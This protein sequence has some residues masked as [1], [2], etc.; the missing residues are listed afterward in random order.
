MIVSISAYIK[1]SVCRLYVLAMITTFMS[2]FAYEWSG[3]SCGEIRDALCVAERSRLSTQDCTIQSPTHSA[4]HDLWRSRSR[5]KWISSRIRF[6]LYQIVAIDLPTFSVKTASLA[7][8]YLS[9]R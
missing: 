3:K 5:A 8:F 4:C 6:L 9:R 2:R 1:P 7:A